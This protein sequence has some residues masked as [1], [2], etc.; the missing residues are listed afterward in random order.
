MKQAIFGT[1][2]IVGAIIYLLYLFDV[3]DSWLWWLLSWV[4]F[5]IGGYMVFNSDEG[6]KK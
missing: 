3:L 4:M 5:G 6:T 1:I 2:A